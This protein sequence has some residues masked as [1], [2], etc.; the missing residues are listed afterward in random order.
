MPTFTLNFLFRRTEV[1]SAGVPTLEP[2]TEARMQSSTPHENNRQNP[3]VGMNTR[4]KENYVESFS[5]PYCNEATKYEKVCKIG[6]GT[7]G[8]V[9][10]AG[11]TTGVLSGFL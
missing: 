6:Q 8:F 10:P 2:L 9:M 3:L 11:D 7:F 4:E 5:F 1:C